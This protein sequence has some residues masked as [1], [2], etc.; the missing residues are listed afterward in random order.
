MNNENQTRKGIVDDYLIKQEFIKLQIAKH[1]GK[2]IDNKELNGFL[3]Y[4]T[5]EFEN[6]TSKNSL[7]N[8][9]I[10][11]GKTITNKFDKY[12]RITSFDKN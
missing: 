8:R 12:K 3:K 7:D 11:I 4:L 2:E 10:S 5:M 9:L 6:N 1:I